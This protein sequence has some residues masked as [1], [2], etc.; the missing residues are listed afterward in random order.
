MESRWRNSPRNR[1]GTA[2][3]CS[4]VVQ[5]PKTPLPEM[6]FVDQTVAPGRRP[7]YCVRSVNSVG[8]KSEPS[9]AVK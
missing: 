3:R 5:T 8:L 4:G 2:D 1:S 6:K 9:A 7:T